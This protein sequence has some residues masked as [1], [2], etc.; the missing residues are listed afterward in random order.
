[1]GIYT[2]D[3][4]GEPTT[5]IGVLSGLPGTQL[6]VPHLPVS[7]YVYDDLYPDSPGSVYHFGFA[8]YGDPLVTT[9]QTGHVIVPNAHVP[10]YWNMLVM[11]PFNT[12]DGQNGCG[13]LN[14]QGPVEYDWIALYEYELQDQ[15]VDN[16]YPNQTSY[17][18][19]CTHYNNLLPA[20]TRFAIGG[21]FPGTLTLSAY[22]P[23]STQFGMPLLDIYDEAGSVVTTEYASSVSS[24]GTQATFPFPASLTQSGYS[25][26]VENQ[27]GSSPG[28]VAAGT[29]LLSIAG[30]ETIAGNPFGVAVG[31]ITDKYIDTDTC[32]K[33][34]SNSS[35]NYSTVPIISLY[36]KNQVLINGEGIGVGANPTAVVAYQGP[37]IIT[38]SSNSC[39]TYLNTYSGTNR[40]I[41]ANSGS[42]TVSII[43]MVNDVLL[44]NVRVGNQPVALAVNSAG[45]EAY[46]AN[47]TDGTVTPV[48]LTAQSAP[49]AVAVGGKPT[50]VALTSAGILW[51]GG[52]GFLTEI[53]T[54]NM[55]VTG[56]ESVSGKTIISLGYSDAYNE[57]AVSSV[58]TSGNVYAEEVTPSTF[59]VGG[60]YAPVASQAASTVGTYLNPVTKENVQGYTATL[61]EAA[62]T[63]INTYQPGAP[64]LVVQDGWAVI[65]ATP[66]GFT[67][68]NVSGNVVLVSQ[69]TP[70]PITAIAVDTN[71]NVA[72]LTMPDSDTIL[73][74]PLPGTK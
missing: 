39:N 47:Y 63:V 61:A 3:C 53:N 73:T 64:P 48:N 70:S 12:F 62:P 15:L 5:Q 66:T 20:S 37:L 36:S 8:V 34:D 35:T 21:S 71:L 45:T 17:D 9:D 16:Y 32:D 7:G 2:S 41:V 11:W 54:A 38:K 26:A 67:I 6:P 13:G 56:T 57:L 68:T 40:A 60:A 58:D 44:S 69:T 33:L 43:D 30:S 19:T 25:L 1:M 72:Y 49:A 23:F 24:D 59:Q 65:T 22:V 31:G 18:F 55:S 51:V 14:Y 4:Q 52:A 46:V 10:D 27:I 50:S 42:N 29:N 28:F 74:V